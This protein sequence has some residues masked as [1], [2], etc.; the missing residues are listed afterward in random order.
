MTRKLKF[1]RVYPITN[2]ERASIALCAPGGRAR[3]WGNADYHELPDEVQHWVDYHR[4]DRVI[5]CKNPLI[6]GILRG[7]GWEVTL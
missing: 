6:A 4:T 7:A 5:R 1:V 3:A 2:S